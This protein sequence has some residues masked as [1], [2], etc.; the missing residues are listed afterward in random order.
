MATWTR[1]ATITTSA[2]QTS[3]TFSS[4]P[5][6]YR[7]LVLNF[8]GGG[9]GSGLVIRFNGDNTAT[10]NVAELYA[11]GTTKT[12]SIVAS[13]A[14]SY[15]TA[16]GVSGGNT[17]VQAHIAD[18]SSTDRHKMVLSRFDSIAPSI[19][20]ASLVGLSS[21]RWANTAAITSITLTNA[22]GA[23]GGIGSGTIVSLYGVT[24]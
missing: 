8:R 13:T 22:S 11:D 17:S 19:G 23:T 20:G 18:Y 24:A 12:G 1:L 10:Y 21:V 9:A 2:S 5:S 3:I 15:L 7:D 4:I 14:N 16:S 6:G